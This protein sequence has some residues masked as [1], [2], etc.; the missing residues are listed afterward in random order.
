MKILRK[1]DVSIDLEKKELEVLADAMDI[2]EEIAS[3]LDDF[4]EDEMSS[5]MVAI[6]EYST[7]ASYTLGKILRK[8][9]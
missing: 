4:D 8:L 3:W 7:D 1:V 2:L 9:Q 5:D 6:H